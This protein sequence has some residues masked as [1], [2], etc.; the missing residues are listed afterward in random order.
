M[1]GG[2]AGHAVN[3]AT[4]VISRVATQVVTVAVTLYAARLLAPEMFGIF[5]ISV[6]WIT[7]V[8]TTFYSGPYEFLLKTPEPR[9]ASSESLVVNLIV[10]LALTLPVFAVVPFSEKLFGSALVGHLLLLLAPSNAIAAFAAWQE[11]LVLRTG[12]LKAYYVVCTVC[13]IVSGVV[14]VALLA[15]GYGLGALVAQVYIRGVLAVGGFLVMRSTVLSERFSPARVLEILRWSVSR[16]VA[17]FLGFGTS[18]SADIVLGVVLSPAASGLFRASN[19]IVTAVSDVIAQPARMIAMTAFS[20]LAA[21]G[22]SADRQWAAMTTAAV[23]VGWSALGGLA[24]VGPMLVPEVLGASW[25]GAAALVPILCAARATSLLD[26]LSGTL[27]VT[28]DR[29]KHALYLQV[30]GTVV[31]FCSILVTSHWGVV[32]AAYGVL[33]ASLVNSTVQ[34]VIAWRHF[35]AAAIEFRRQLV[36]MAAPVIATVA[37]ALIALHLS[38]GHLGAVL[39]TVVVMMAGAGSWAFSLVAMRRGLWNVVMSMKSEA[40]AIV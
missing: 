35:P 1:R 5:A 15:M 8:R 33:G 21:N 3:A 18:Y 9:T 40:S 26:T 34:M 14:A 25:I 7:L 28:Y 38:Q 36:L 16:Y 19:R 32:G 39:A 22:R 23:V 11:V 2:A 10:G 6:A 4:G 37:G 13:D 29:Q 20:S 31:M 12:R 30:M 27:M 24:V 17:V